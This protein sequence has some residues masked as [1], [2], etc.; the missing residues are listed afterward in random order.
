MSDNDNNMTLIGWQRIYDDK[1]E[2]KEIR[3]IQLVIPPKPLGDCPC[4]IVEEDDDEDDDNDNGRILPHSELQEI[5][6]TFK[7]MEL[8]GIPASVTM[9]EFSKNGEEEVLIYLD[10]D[11]LVTVEF[12]YNNFN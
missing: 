6:E 5:K 10:K 7:P 11:E 4:N 2:I 8:L 1:G 9:E 12:I 3:T